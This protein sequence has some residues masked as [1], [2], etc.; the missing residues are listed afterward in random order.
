MGWDRDS[1][2]E[3]VKKWGW[4]C[5]AVMLAAVVSWQ[6][7]TLHAQ[8]QSWRRLKGKADELLMGGVGGGGRNAAQTESAPDSRTVESTF[9]NRPKSQYALTAILDHHAV[10]NGQEVK[11]GDRVGR[12]LVQKI[13][14]VSVTI[15]EDGKETPKKIE[16]H[17]GL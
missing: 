3:A 8:V 15:L 5:A 2:E 17:P 6:G 12:G 10:I 11:V 16:L 14:P 9:F 1:A 4:T 7:L 13:E